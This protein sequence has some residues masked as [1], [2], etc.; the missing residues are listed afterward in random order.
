VRLLCLVLM[1]VLAAQDLPNGESRQP[2]P[3]IDFQLSQYD[4]PYTS[5][6]SGNIVVEFVI[7]EK[8][9][10]IEPEITDTFNVS[11]NDI[12]LDKVR[13]MKFTPPMQNGIPIK[14]KYKLPIKFK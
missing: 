1:G 13:R 10:V 8:G 6:S 9:K 12:V 2:Q 11:F 14:V 5:N 7:D 3:I 4:L